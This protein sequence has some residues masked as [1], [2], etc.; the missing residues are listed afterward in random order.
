M[1]STLPVIFVSLV[2]WGGFISPSTAC[3]TVATCKGIAFCINKLD[4]GNADT[5]KAIS[6]AASHGDGNGVGVDTAACQHKFGGG[7]WDAASAGCTNA[8][9]AALGKKALNGSAG[10]D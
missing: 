3:D 8:D 4:A 7:S 5:S 2:F 6:T 1:R 10:C 9:Y